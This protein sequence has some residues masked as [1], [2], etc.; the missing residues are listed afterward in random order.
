[1]C[2]L[3]DILNLPVSSRPKLVMWVV[4]LALQERV[5][6]VLAAQEDKACADLPL[7]SYATVVHNVPTTASTN[8]D[9]VV[10]GNVQVHVSRQTK[11]CKMEELGESVVW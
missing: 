2:S 11:V 10:N 5:A 3:E 7:P 6:H 1:M 8:V 4:V 9:S